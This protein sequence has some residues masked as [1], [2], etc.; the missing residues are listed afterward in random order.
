MKTDY[1]ISSLCFKVLE[2]SASSYLSDLLHVYTRSLQLRSS[3]DDQFSMFLAS[4]QSGMVNALLLIRELPP[5]TSSNSLLG[6][7]SL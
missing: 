5:G 3:S 6:I 2:S 7:C 4:E 1:K